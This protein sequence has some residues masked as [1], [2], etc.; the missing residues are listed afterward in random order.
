MMMPL[1]S[2]GARTRLRV[3]REWWAGRMEG[4]AGSGHLGDAAAGLAQCRDPGRA[5][6]VVDYEPALTVKVL[7]PAAGD[8]R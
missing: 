3:P 2:S 6:K 5:D 4:E 1:S 8:R 7:Q